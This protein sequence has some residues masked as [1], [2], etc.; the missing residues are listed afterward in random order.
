MNEKEKKMSV[1]I[2]KLCYE[3]FLEAL[4]TE[5]HGFS[6]QLAFQQILFNTVATSTEQEMALLHGASALTCIHRSRKM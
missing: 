6:L 1:K 5:P 2:L 4:L 3:E